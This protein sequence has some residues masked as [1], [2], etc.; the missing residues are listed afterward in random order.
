MRAPKRLKVLNYVQTMYLVTLNP[1]MCLSVY[2]IMFP[3]IAMKYIII[4]IRK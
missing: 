4:T 3:I 1:C 2:D